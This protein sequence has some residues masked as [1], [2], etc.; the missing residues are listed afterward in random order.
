ESFRTYLNRQKD[1]T[2]DRKESFKNL[3]KFTKKLTKIMPGDKSEIKRL[4]DEIAAT[5][6]VASLNWIQEKIEELV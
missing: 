4:K 5:G 1:I 6:N 3:I 2:P